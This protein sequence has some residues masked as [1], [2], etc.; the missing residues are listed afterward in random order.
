MPYPRRHNSHI[1][2]VVIQ[3]VCHILLAC[4][5][6]NLAMRALPYNRRVVDHHIHD[7]HEYDPSLTVINPALIRFG[8]LFSWQR[9]GSSGVAHVDSRV[10]MRTRSQRAQPNEQILPCFRH[11]SAHYVILKELLAQERSA[12][13]AKAPRSRVIGLSQSIGD[14]SARSLFRG[15]LTAFRPSRQVISRR[16]SNPWR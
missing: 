12:V 1:N 10:Y 13:N 15:R 7:A 6:R 14:S 3:R 16:A 9:P 2:S 4:R 11:G 5:E 8:P